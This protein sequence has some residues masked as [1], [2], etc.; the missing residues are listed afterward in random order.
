MDARAIAIERGVSEATPEPPPSGRL[1]SAPRMQLSE[2]LWGIRWGDLLP[3]Q[4]TRDVTVVASSFDQALPFIE[5]NYSTIFEDEG[6][7]RFFNPQSPTLKA[8]YYRIAGDF[9][10]FKQGPRTVG[11]LIGTAV[12]WSTYYIRS[13]AA[14]PEIQGSQMI[15]RFFTPMFAFLKAAG[16]ERIEAETSPTNMAVIHLLSRMRFNPSGTVL[17]DRWGA[18]LR[19][20]RYLDEGAERVFIKQYCAGVHYQTKGHAG[21]KRASV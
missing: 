9:F 18:L 16:V 19:L 12:D 17:T 7:A 20:T 1:E 10:E 14:L 8:R 3:Q 2:T 15:Q 6:D 21:S 4:V 5:V 13:A 11:L